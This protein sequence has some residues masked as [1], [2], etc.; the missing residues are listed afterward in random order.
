MMPK[1]RPRKELSVRAPRFSDWDPGITALA[2]VVLG[3][4]DEGRMKA[5]SQLVM[6]PCSKRSVMCAW[7]CRAGL[8]LAMLL[9]AT[10]VAMP[11]GNTHSDGAVCSPGFDDHVFLGDDPQEGEPA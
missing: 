11:I 6:Q 3:A 8:V 1:L 4:G 7:T 2:P 9:V 10:R 5:N